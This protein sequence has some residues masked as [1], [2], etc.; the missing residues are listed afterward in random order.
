MTAAGRPPIARVRPVR[1][2]SHAAIALAAAVSLAGC[3]VGDGDDR[4]PQLGAKSGDDD[5]AAKLGFPSTATKNTIRVGGGDA[6]A[7]AA[8]VASAVFPGT[9][10]TGR[11]TAV[12][13]VEKDDWQAGVTAAALTARPI[14]APILISDDGEL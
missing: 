14:G 10:D 7:D 12:V 6:A 3:S 13:L 5:A 2:R 4:P 8:G 11:P 1:V 9:T